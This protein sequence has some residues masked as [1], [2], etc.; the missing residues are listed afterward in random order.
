MKHDYE[1]KT[2]AAFCVLNEL[3]K[4]TNED[5]KVVLYVLFYTNGN[6]IKAL[7]VLRGRTELLWTVEEDRII[8]K[9]NEKEIRN[10]I[11]KRGKIEVAERISFL[12]SM[13]RDPVNQSF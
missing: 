6:F 1:I 2:F 10:L 12:E 3:K 7:S 4:R 11:D 9:E 13:K 5:E 8:I